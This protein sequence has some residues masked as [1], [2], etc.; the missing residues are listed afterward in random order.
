MRFFVHFPNAVRKIT[1]EEFEKERIENECIEKERIEKERI[2]NECIEKERI[3]KE[4]IE[5]EFNS[6]VDKRVNM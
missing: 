2:K 5:N 6:A 4:R 1:P 3:E